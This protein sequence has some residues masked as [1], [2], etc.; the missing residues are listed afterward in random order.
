M[1]WDSLESFSWFWIAGYSVLYSALVFSGEM[2]KEGPLIFSKRNA[3]S[4]RQ[5]LFGHLLFLTISIALYRVAVAIDSHVPNW[6]S[7]YAGRG[8]TWY[9]GLFL[10][11]LLVLTY[12]ER[13]WLFLPSAKPTHKIVRERDRSEY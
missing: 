3:R 10:V 12:I 8:G 5:I 9:E 2:S 13:K 7:E 1:H 11:A 6:M 4:A